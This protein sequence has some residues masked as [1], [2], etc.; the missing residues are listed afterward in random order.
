[1]RLINRLFVCLAVFFSASCGQETDMVLPQEE[2]PIVG[3]PLTVHASLGGNDFT[4]TAMQSDETSIFWTLNDAINLFYGELYSGKFTSKITEPNISTDFTGILNAATG[5]VQ[6]GGAARQFWGVYPYNSTNTC[7]GDAVYLTIPSKQRGTVGSFANKLNPS[8]ARSSGLDLAFYNVGSWFRFT[9]GQDDIVSATFKGNNNETVSGRVRVSMNSKSRPVYQVVE[10]K[11]T[12]TITPSQTECFLANQEY[13]IVLLPQTFQSG[14]TLILT[15]S[16]GTSAEFVYSS[17]VPF[18]RSYSNRKLLADSGLVF[19]MNESGDHNVVEDLSEMGTANSYIVSKAGTY[20]FKA[21]Q[22]NTNVPVEGIMGVKVLWKTFGNGTTPTADDIIPDTDVTF[23]DGFITFSTSEAFSEG[24][25]VIAAYSDAECTYGN[26]LWSWHIWMTDEPK[27]HVYNNFAGI[28]MDRNIG[29]TSVT[30]GEIAAIGLFY[31]WGRKDPFL[32]PQSYTL[33]DYNNNLKLAASRINTS[34]SKWP[35]RSNV[36]T[37]GAQIDFAI[38]NPATIASYNS[39]NQDWYYTETTSTDNT[40]WNSSKGVQ[41]PC[42]PGWRV[43][44]GGP[45]GT[46]AKA[47]GTYL[48]IDPI[49]FDYENRGVQLGASSIHSLG[50]EDYIWYPLSGGYSLSDGLFSISAING[51]CWSCTPCDFDS[52]AHAFYY[53]GVKGLSSSR[54][55]TPT[56]DAYRANGYP[57]RCV[58]E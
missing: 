42:P 23:G 50:N 33:K 22:G 40:R 58:Q 19:E 47:L 41:D 31:Q 36:N 27:E 38:A 3:T 46:W 57:V 48:K 44:D 24:N 34:N 13:W 54:S 51:Y 39:M 52:R 45:S 29:A 4:R 5:T 7:D 55:L 6:E 16:D 15:K 53:E 10:G 14:F 37:P 26:V 8:V 43:P 25:A 20:M 1:M 56:I 17:S 32:G 35:S 49:E 12:I 9:V 2:N 28:M 30:P 18:D 21:M 11:N